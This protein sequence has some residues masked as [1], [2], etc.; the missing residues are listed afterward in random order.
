MVL[1][2]FVERITEKG[3]VAKILDQGRRFYRFK[4]YALYAG[5]VLRG[6][7]S[8]R[9]QHGA[10]GLQPQPHLHAGRRHSGHASIC[11]SVHRPVGRNHRRPR[12]RSAVPPLPIPVLSSNWIIDWRRFHEVLAANPAGRAAQ[13]IAE[14]R[15]VPVPQLH[16]TAGR[17]RQPAVPQ[18]EARRDAGPSVGTGRRQGD[19]DQKSAH[20]GRDREGDRTAPWP[21]STACT[22]IRRSGTTSSRRPSSAAAA[23]G[24]AGRRHDRGGSVR[25]PRAWRPPVVPLAEGQG[26]EADAAVADTLATSPWPTCCGSSATSALSTGFR[27]SRRFRRLHPSLARLRGANAAQ[28]Q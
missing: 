4:K 10:R 9:S 7:L 8:A 3:I 13:R 14:D 18:P 24:S 19:E 25:R 16:D 26:L 6:R 23:K 5:R 17:R 27:R 21:R 20:P 22:S 28:S 1:H 11:C 15:S 12:A 2:D